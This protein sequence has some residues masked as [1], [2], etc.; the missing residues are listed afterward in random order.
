NVTLNEAV[1]DSSGVPAAR[2]RVDDFP[3]ERERTLRIASLAHDVLERLRP[4][5]I[6]DDT[7]FGRTF[8]LQAGTCRMGTDASTSVC[9]ARGRVHGV[10]RLYI[11]DGSV[12]PTMGGVPPTLTIMANALRIAEGILKNGS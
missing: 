1:V 6:T 7:P 3:G 8:F 5:G 9:D 10:E 2:I 11:C 4:A 12:L